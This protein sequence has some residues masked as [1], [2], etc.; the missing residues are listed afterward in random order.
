VVLLSQTTEYAL[1]AMVQLATVQATAGTAVEV[2]AVLQTAPEIAE[3]DAGP[4]KLL[5][6]VLQQLSGWLSTSIVGW[7]AV[8]FDR[9][10]SVTTVYDVVQ[11]VDPI[12]RL[13]GCPLNLPAHARRLCPMHT[14]LTGPQLRSRNSSAAARSMSSSITE[15]HRPSTAR[16]PPGGLRLAGGFCLRPRRYSQAGA[17][18]MAATCTGRGGFFFPPGG[19]GGS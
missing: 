14:R 11:A 5:S 9:D 6:K 12:E 16:G 18:V 4:A 7:E 1:R 8:F 10:P 19:D 13:T 2:Q 17:R 3:G 15:E